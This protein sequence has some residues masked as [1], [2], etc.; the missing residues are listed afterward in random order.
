MHIETS[1]NPIFEQKTFNKTRRNG[2]SGD[3]TLYAAGLVIRKSELTKVWRASRGASCE[4][5]EC[6]HESSRFKRIIGINRAP[7]GI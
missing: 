7:W 2:S 5:E 4:S 3:L 6:F 1:E